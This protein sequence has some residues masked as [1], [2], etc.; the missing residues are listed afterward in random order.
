V[1][2][3]RHYANPSFAT[4]LFVSVLPILVYCVLV[5][6]VMIV[7]PIIHQRGLAIPCCE[8]VSGLV[9]HFLREDIGGAVGY[10]VLTRSCSIVANLILLEAAGETDEG[11]Y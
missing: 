9:D 2:S 11:E 1:L 8:A 3:L 10:L 6:I 4:L 5:F 7:I